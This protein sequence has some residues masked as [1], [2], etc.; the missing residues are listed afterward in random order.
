MA[1]ESILIIEDEPLVR[2]ILVQALQMKGYEVH[3]AADGPSGL[4]MFQTLGPQLVVLDLMLP[5][6][7]G[8]EVCRQIRELSSVPILVTTACKTD[9]DLVRALEM[10][11][12]HYLIKPFRAAELQAW[13]KVLLK[14]AAACSAQE[15]SLVRWATAAGVASTSEWHLG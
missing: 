2:S 1:A 8:W 11:A 4:S 3:V 6:M 7:S 10:G 5:E 15:E 9:Q 12:D 14:R 13:V